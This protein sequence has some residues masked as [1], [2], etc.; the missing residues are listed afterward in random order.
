MSDRTS[1]SPEIALEST[2][3]AGERAVVF[4][5]GLEGAES[6]GRF[7]VLETLGRGGMGVVV[8]AFDPE[9]SRKVAIKVLRPDAA[10][11]SA[12]QG[13]AR[14][15]REAQA[16]AQVSSPNVI[17]VHDVGT[18]GDSVYIAMELVEGQSLRAWQKGRG[19]REVLGAYLQAGRGLAAAHAAELVHRDFKP[20]NVLVDREGRVRVTDFGLA[21]AGAE[22]IRGGDLGAELTSST[23]LTASLT[24]TGALVGTPAY[25]S[26]EQHLGEPADARADQFAFCVALAEA[27]G[28]ERPFSGRTYDDLRAAVLAGEHRL[29]KAKNIPA[30]IRR[31]LERGLSVEAGDRFPSMQALIAALERSP[32]QR[33]PIA[34]AVLAGAVIAGA[35]AFALVTD[36]DDRCDDATAPLDAVWNP[37]IEARLQKAFSASGHPYAAAR[38]ERVA[39]VLG[40]YASSW[41]GR[42]ERLCRE[43]PEDPRERARRRLCRDQAVAAFE[44]LVAELEAVEAGRLDGLAQGLLNVKLIDCPEAPATVAEPTVRDLRIELRVARVLQAVGFTVEARERLDALKPRVEATGDDGL[45]ADHLYWQAV[46]QMTAGKPEEALETARLVESIAARAG[47][48]PIRVR[49]ALLAADAL[50]HSDLEAAQVSVDRAARYLEGWDAPVRLTATLELAAGRLAF[51]RGNWSEALAH[52]TRMRDIGER[53]GDELIAIAA[54]DGV[55]SAL[56]KL[57]RI[58]EAVEIHEKNL[59]TRR[60][61]FGDSDEAVAQSHN[62]LASALYT[63]GDAGGALGHMEKA[64]A[65]L[66]AVRGE[67]HPTVLII[68]RN[69][70]ELLAA[71]G[72][73]DESL[74]RAGEVLEVATRAFGADSNAAADAHQVRS[75]PLVLLGRLDE[76]LA[77]LEA[78]LA[79]YQAR[80]NAPPPDVVAC[81]TRLAEVLRGLDRPTEALEHARQAVS[82]TL[83]IEG[84]G[85]LRLAV[86]RKEEGLALLALGRA[87]QA[88]SLLSKT[89]EAVAG[90]DLRDPEIAEV[91]FAYARALWASSGDRSRARAEALVAKD[92]FA[93]AGGAYERAR[94]EVERW[95]A[96]R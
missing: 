87:R 28:G 76:A 1:E 10:G 85:S 63:R 65:I 42:A 68:A 8:A 24:H 29:G 82:G 59:A 79:I 53:A 4:E 54:S 80:P 17:A 73:F 30:W 45:I 20:D 35:A 89:L 39:S 95:L 57:G 51:F 88:S 31:V 96:E 15:L 86:P 25:M 60:R 9:L 55:G 27:L 47:R 34:A 46:S 64:R 77:E 52:F 41:R 61:V 92:A 71:V 13:R 66:G 70:A 5:P 81:H 6:I 12:T 7:E 44:A 90:S 58:D 67:G 19:W 56:E 74:T 2:H 26:P 18:V 83:S 72:R 16:M 84:E 11:E 50:M 32:R 21:S 40:G 23:P 69:T 37:A 93:R 48:R 91:R 14:L 75:I 3:A 38:W 62:H 33:W 78:A 22:A 49:A 36:R 94:R 43:P